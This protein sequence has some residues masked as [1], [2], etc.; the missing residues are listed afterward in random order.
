M[1]RRFKKTFVGDGRALEWLASVILLAISVTFALPGDTLASSAA[2]RG[3]LSLGFNEGSLTLIFGVVAMS[4]M[5][6]LYINGNWKRSPL[7]R[8]VGSTISAGI[9]GFIALTF[10][11]PLFL[12]VSNAVTTAVGTYMIITSVEILAAYRAATD[13]KFPQRH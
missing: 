4:R 12:G 5:A 1:K 9:F 11:S 6:G 8:M 3:F 10:L 2:F 7:L 13:A